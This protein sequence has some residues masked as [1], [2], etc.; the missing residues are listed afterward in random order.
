MQAGGHVPYVRVAAR[1]YFSMGNTP[2]LRRRE[3]N[4]LRR[5]NHGGKYVQPLTF[6]SLNFLPVS[7]CVLSG[8]ENLLR[9]PF[10]HIYVSG[11]LPPFSIASFPQKLR[12]TLPLGERHDRRGLRQ[13]P[14]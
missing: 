2:E 11:F 3:P 5:A 6:F 8:F 12:L 13:A 7:S 10:G 14:S 1:C 4:C 9:V